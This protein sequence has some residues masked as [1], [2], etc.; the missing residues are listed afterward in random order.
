MNEFKRPSERAFSSVW[1]W[2][3]YEN[4]LNEGASQKEKTDFYTR[5]NNRFLES[6]HIPKSRVIHVSKNSATVIINASESEISSIKKNSLCV[7]VTPYLDKIPQKTTSEV[8]LSQI[9]ADSESGTNSFLFGDGNG[10]SGEGVTVGM[11]SAERS[12]FDPQSPQLIPALNDGRITVIEFEIPPQRDL[13]PSVV[14]SEII[15]AET[16]LNGVTYSGILPKCR[17][18]FAS[19]ETEKDVFEA[20]DMMIALG[21]RVVN[22]SAGIIGEEEYRNFDRQIDRIVESTGILFVTVSGNRRTVASAGISYSAL[23]V[24]NLQTKTAPSIPARPPYCTWCKDEI[25]CS[26]YS[27]TTLYAHKPDVVAPGVYIPYISS[28]NEIISSIN[29]GTSFACPWVTGIAG[30]IIEKTGIASHLPLKTIIAASCDRAIV[31]DVNNPT[32]SGEAFAREKTGFG[33]VNA[34]SAVLCAKNSEILSLQGEFSRSVFLSP[35]DTLIV[36]VCFNKSIERE[37]ENLSLYINAPNKTL[38]AN[39][40]NQ[41][42]HVLEYTPD[43]NEETVISS[44]PNGNFLYSLVIWIKKRL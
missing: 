44:I 39:R 25:N 43:R 37:N 15:G 10:L 41:N 20:L 22:Y 7:D 23:T 34:Q 3:C 1:V 11:I 33:L 35:T 32:L 28:Q 18:I 40:E 21:V 16:Y 26:G 42:L 17:V 24:G 8:I 6:E 29:V 13:H 31:C 38:V 4:K 27:S 2:L 9:G 5:E 30:Q 14:L 12:I 36:G 19:T